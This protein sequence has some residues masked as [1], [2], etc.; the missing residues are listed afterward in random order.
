M[1][2]SS[3][4]LPIIPTTKI[5]QDTMVFTYLKA[6]LIS[7]GFMHM[8]GKE[9]RGRPGCCGGSGTDVLLL[10]VSEASGPPWVSRANLE[11][12]TTAT[13]RRHIRA[14]ALIFT[15]ASHSRSKMFAHSKAR[16]SRKITH[17]K[18][19]THTHIHVLIPIR[20]LGP[21]PGLTTCPSLFVLQ[22]KHTNHH[23]THKQLHFYLTMYWTDCH[24]ILCRH[25]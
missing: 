3:V 21:D 16:G 17:L 19:L 7:V 10:E 13:I 20:T 18:A 9:P 15:R 25:S 1:I 6:C 8:G 14:R 12:P 23:V 4:E 24:K 2:L 11:A 5:R 22:R